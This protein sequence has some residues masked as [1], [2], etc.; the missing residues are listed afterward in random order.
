MEMR[1]EEF[2]NYSQEY[3]TFLLRSL[4]NNEEK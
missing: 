2:T 3:C 4:G 1:K